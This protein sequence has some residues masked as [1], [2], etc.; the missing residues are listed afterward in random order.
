TNSTGQRVVRIGVANV[1]LRLG[2]G[3][4]SCQQPGGGANGSTVALVTNGQGFFLLAPDGLA[5]SIGASV[6]LTVPGVTFEGQFRLALNKTGRAID[7]T[8]TVGGQTVRL[9]LP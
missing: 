8:I 7:E 4:G 1:C 6:A 5:G 9:T 3:S 2:G